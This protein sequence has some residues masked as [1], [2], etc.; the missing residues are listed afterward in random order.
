[1]RPITLLVLALLCLLP[2]RGFAQCIVFNTTSNEIFSTVKAAVN[3]ASTGDT[4]LV[5]NC[6][7]QETGI[8]I[9]DS[10][11]LRLVGVPGVTTLDGGGRNETILTVTG[12]ARVTI[13]GIT[14][15][16]G[17]SSD[18]AGGDGGAINVR[19]QGHAI[20]RDCVFQTNGSPNHQ[21]GAVVCRSDSTM[22]IE[23]SIFR[24][25]LGRSN[26]N[27]P[28]AASLFRSRLIMVNCVITG[29]TNG[30]SAV[31]AQTD[32]RLEVINCTFADNATGRAIRAGDNARLELFNSVFD[33][34]NPILVFG[35]SIADSGRNVFPGADS[36]DINATPVFVNAASGDYRLAA[37]SPGIDA[38]DAALYSGPMLD[39]L[40]S[41]RLADDREVANGFE[42]P[43]DCGAFERPSATCSAADFAA[44]FGVVDLSDV[45]AFVQSFLTGCP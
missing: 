7:F 16:N 2:S 40:G 12:D 45:D 17:V 10:R 3:Q 25:N 1:M 20:V 14:F 11:D 37:G 38:A 19:N 5:G 41:A 44:P 29:T 13:E 33:R 9:D 27:A 8:V 30:S 18:P 21:L 43:L 34:N 39:P 23:N 15:R 4:L 42:P 22:R 32:S 6:T 24:D 26:A 35:E 28:A 36:P 31:Y